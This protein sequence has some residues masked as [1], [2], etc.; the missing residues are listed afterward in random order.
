MESA[1]AA[2]AGVEALCDAVESRFERVDILVNNAGIPMVRDSA[3]L[4]L[5]DWQRT[6]D[7]NLTAP[8]LCAQRA[9][10]DMLAKGGGNIVNIASVTAFA[11]FPKRLAYATTKAGLVMMTRILAAEWAPTVRVNAVA[12]GFIKTGLVM[13]LAGEGRGDLKER[14]GGTQ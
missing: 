13:G 8:F 11:P 12:P 7:I 2:P 5:A 4:S 3:E 14:E 10:R 9:G 6:L 1:L